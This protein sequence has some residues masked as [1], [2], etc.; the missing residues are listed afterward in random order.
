MRKQK[1]SVFVC[2]CVTN[3]QIQRKYNTHTHTKTEQTLTDNFVESTKWKNKLESHPE[4]KR[5]ELCFV[6]LLKSD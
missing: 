3:L 4:N 5:D 1:Y 6:D 2:V